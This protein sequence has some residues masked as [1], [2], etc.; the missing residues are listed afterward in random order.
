MFDFF[1]PATQYAALKQEIDTVINS[2]QLKD[3]K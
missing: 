2:F 3:G 1:A